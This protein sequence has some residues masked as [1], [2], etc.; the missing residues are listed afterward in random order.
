ML[1]EAICVS[2]EREGVDEVDEEVPICAA[3]VLLSLVNILLSFKFPRW[4]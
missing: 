1:V 3:G 4:S 2:I